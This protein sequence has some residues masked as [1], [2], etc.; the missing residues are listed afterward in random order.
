MNETLKKLHE[1]GIDAI[2][3][4]T[5]ISIHSLKAILEERFADISHIQYI[6]FLTLIEADMHIDMSELRASYQA[7]REDTGQA[8][9]NRELFVSTPKESKNYKPLIISVISIALV[10]VF[11]STMSPKKSSEENFETQA[12][13]S[14]IEK[15]AENIKADKP[16]EGVAEKTSLKIPKFNATQAKEDEV[17]SI[18]T[19]PF[20]LYPKEALWIGIVNMDKKSQRDTITS[21][22]YVLDENANLLI[23][24]GHG[25]VKVDLNSDITDLK[26]QGRVRF[27]Y[28]NGVLKRISLAKFI[29]LNEGKS[30]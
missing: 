11:I 1:I 24:L 4:Q 12:E 28:I 13:N 10:I 25:L 2:H 23:T 30:W 7:Y 14:A 16:A 6:G 5:H 29:E 22:P 18:N 21:A 20:V 26:D 9:D 15:A 19:H 27:S 3:V 8:D 17:K